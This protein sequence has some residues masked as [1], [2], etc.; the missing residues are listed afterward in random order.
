MKNPDTIHSVL[1][2]TLASLNS[3]EEENISQISTQVYIWPVAHC[4]DKGTDDV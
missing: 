2:K 3:Q 4:Y 1:Q